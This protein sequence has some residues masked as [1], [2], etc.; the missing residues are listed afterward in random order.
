ME[1]LLDQHYDCFALPQGAAEDLL[2]TALVHYGTFWE[3]REFFVAEDYQL[4]QLTAKA[5]MVVHCCILSRHLNPRCAWCFVG[6][7]FMGKMRD[8]CHSC[9]K[10][11]SMWQVSDK[12][13]EKWLVAMHLTMT[14]P[15]AWFK[16]G[17]E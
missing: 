13:V 16:R 15:E 3:L 1:W 7:D 17:F 4:F 6:E 2:S 9:A 12:V 14:D 8:L 10:G 11:S 5:H